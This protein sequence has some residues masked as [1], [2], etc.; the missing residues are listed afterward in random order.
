MSSASEKKR[1]AEA[2]LASARGDL[3]QGKTKTAQ[4]QA[5]Q[6]M[7]TA[8][9]A[10]DLAGEA[11]AWHVI[12]CAR[13]A[14]G[15]FDGGVGAAEAALALFGGELGDQRSEAAT[16]R[17]LARWRIKQGQ[18]SEALA[19]ALK[20]LR[21]ATRSESPNDQVL[22]LEQVVQA[23]LEMRRP[24]E[25]KLAAK[26]V[27]ASLQLFGDKLAEISALRLLAKACRIA[28]EPYE[29]TDAA[30]RALD[31][32]KELGDKQLEQTAQEE[33]TE[34]NTTLAGT[35]EEMRIAHAAER[36][37]QVETLYETVD[38]LKNRHALKYKQGMEKLAKCDM[39]TQQE[40]DEAFAPLY[41]GE[42]TKD[43]EEFAKWAPRL[44]TEGG[45]HLIT[46][47]RRNLYM[48]MRHY[49]MGYGP[50]YRMV[51]NS[52]AEFDTKIIKSEREGICCGA[53]TLDPEGAMYDWEGMTAWHAGLLDCG[54]QV[55]G[56]R[57]AVFQ[58]IYLRM[59]R[60]E[61]SS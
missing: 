12:C 37:S 42:D 23:N 48:T 15:D 33:L 26:Q 36:D 45:T 53:L 38:A 18:A 54:L 55:Q 47:D 34:I 27:A 40:I 17:E 20:A 14:N 59:Q 1:M 52:C 29:A 7:V 30:G 46:V 61:E 19:S 2:A 60:E 25:A 57:N 8:H 22:G 11:A 43:V 41:E 50:Q 24:R 21:L 3:A 35:M 49:G 5:E 56:T 51:H 28:K 39:I 58:D 32:A 31:L 16:L 6:A 4:Q 13:F 44:V 9:Q 10:G